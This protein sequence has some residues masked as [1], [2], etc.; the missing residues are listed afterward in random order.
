MTVSLAGSAISKGQK[1]KLERLYNQQKEKYDRYLAQQADERASSANTVD[2]TRDSDSMI[3]APN[4]L[5]IA[6]NMQQLSLGQLADD[7]SL[8]EHPPN[9]HDPGDAKVARI[10]AGTFG[11]RQGLRVV[12]ECGPFFHMFSC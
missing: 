3:C 11:N 8:S 7:Q 1:K 4:S 9:E 5:D 6:S 2:D 12:A 10:I